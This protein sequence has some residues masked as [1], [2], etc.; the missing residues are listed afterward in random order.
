[1]PD[2]E[3]P[4]AVADLLVRLLKQ[5]GVRHVFGDPGGPLTPIYAPSLASRQSAPSSP[6]WATAVSR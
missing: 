4:R 3:L 1:M 5:D 2:Q 6:W